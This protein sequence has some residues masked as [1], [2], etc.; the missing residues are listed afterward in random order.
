MMEIC[1]EGHKEERPFPEAPSKTTASRARRF[2]NAFRA[3]AMCAP[4]G[5]PGLTNPSSIF[6]AIAACEKGNEVSQALGNAV[7]SLRAGG[8]EVIGHHEDSH[9]STPCPVDADEQSE[10][11]LGSPLLVQEGPRCSLYCGRR[12]HNE[13]GEVRFCLRN[14]CL[15]EGHL[16]HC[17]CWAH[18]RNYQR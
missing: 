8:A 6:E 7:R 3:G 2:R 11:A 15:S 14:C 18:A 16:G 9:R 12:Y 4:Y 1:T 13:E 17:R 5:P 10:L